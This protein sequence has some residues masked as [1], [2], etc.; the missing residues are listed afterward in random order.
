MKY[1]VFN[2]LRKLSAGWIVTLDVLKSALFGSVN[3]EL[4]SWIV[5]LDVLKLEDIT[6]SWNEDVVE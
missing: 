2:A 6:D 4:K 5:T 1:D 3:D